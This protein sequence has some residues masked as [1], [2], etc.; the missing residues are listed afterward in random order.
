MTTSSRDTPTSPGLRRATEFRFRPPRKLDA[1]CRTIA[2]ARPRK[3][4]FWIFPVAV[5]GSSSTML[6]HCG[7]AGVD[8]AV[9]DRLG[10][11]FRIPVVPLEHDVA[12]DDDLA[13][14]A[15]VVGHLFSGFGV[16]DAQVA[17]RDQLHALPR[18][19]RGTL[20]G[21]QRGMFG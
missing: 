2:G 17:G 7:I 21:R 13:D 5:F 16:D 3:T 18:L 11:G 19:D 14:R 6:N 8:P 12:A 1:Y 10:G 4:N 9:A 20:G 15:S